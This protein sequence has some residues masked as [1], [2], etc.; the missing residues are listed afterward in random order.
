[1]TTD[2]ESVIDALAVRRIVRGVAEGWGE[3]VR[4]RRESRQFEVE[5]LAQLVGVSANTIK[6]VETGEIVARDRVRWAI[7][8]YPCSEVDDLFP[9][10]NRAVIAGVTGRREDVA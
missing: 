6:R 9:A 1:M 8:H 7:A 2:T 10:P 3:L 4:A 5:D